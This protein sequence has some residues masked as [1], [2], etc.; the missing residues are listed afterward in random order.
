MVFEELRTIICEHLK[1]DESEI[2]MDT[3]IAD[4]L[5]MDSLDLLDLDMMI[6]DTFG[7]KLEEM[8]NIVKVSDIVEY[9]E[10]NKK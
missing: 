10:K 2:S 7:V 6:E 8:E 5:Q 9:I 1:M 3:S 4:D